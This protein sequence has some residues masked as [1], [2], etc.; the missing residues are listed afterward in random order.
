MSI[1]AFFLALF[2]LLPIEMS[3]ILD[4]KCKKRYAIWRFS[5]RRR[6]SIFILLTEVIALYIGFTLI[7]IKESGF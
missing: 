3:L 4:K 2:L 7:N 1:M 6:K 5:T